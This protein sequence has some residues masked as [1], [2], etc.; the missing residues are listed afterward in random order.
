[1]IVLYAWPTPNGQKIAIML[2]ECGLD[3]EAVAVDINA[4]EQFAPGFLALSPN[5]RIPAIVDDEGPDG[6]CIGLFESGAILQYLAE[7]TGR[8]M[9]RTGEGRYRVV[10]WLMFQMGGLGP[11]CGQAHHFRQRMGGEDVP[12]GIERYTREVGRLYGV[13]DR[14]LA[15]NPYLAGGAYSI[16]DIACWPWVRPHRRQGQDLADFPA[17]GRWFGEIRARPAVER[18]MMLL[19]EHRG[20]RELTPEARDLLFGAGQAAR[21]GGGE[22]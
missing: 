5:N 13:M 22:G 3:Y 17:L 2:E 10:E 6:G 16:A 8:F 4:G 21:A 11:M 14:R 15:D 18:G 12:Y 20:R 9:P 7:K 1:M 19:D